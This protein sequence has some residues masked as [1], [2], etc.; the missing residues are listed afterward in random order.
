MAEC[1]VRQ[2]LFNF[3]CF[4]FLILEI[5]YVILFCLGLFICIP[6]NLSDFYELSCCPT[7]E[8]ATIT[9]ISSLIFIILF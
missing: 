4:V 5:F 2:L 3:F 7:R 6:L 9:I 1:S 8:L